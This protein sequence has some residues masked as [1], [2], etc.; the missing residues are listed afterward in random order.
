G[1]MNKKTVRDI[2]LSGKRVLVRVDY[3]VPLDEQGRITDNSRIRET[4]PTLTYLREQG[5]RVVLVSHLGRPDGKADPKLSLKPVAQ[6]LER[7]L[8]APVEFASDSIG[9]QAHAC[10]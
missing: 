9:S 5:C 3:N 1:R 10:V 8:N 2:D 6:E 7:L 4:L